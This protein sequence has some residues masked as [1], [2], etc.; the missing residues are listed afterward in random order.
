MAVTAI[1]ARKALQQAGIIEQKEGAPSESKPLYDILNIW[2][3]YMNLVDPESDAEYAAKLE[4]NLHAWAESKGLPLSLF[5]PGKSPITPPEAPGEASSIID[6]GLALITALNTIGIIAEAAS[7]GQIESVIWAMTNIINATGLPKVIQDLY[8]IPTEVGLKTALIYQM[9]RTFQPRLPDPGALTDLRAR[10][11]LSEDLYTW[12]MRQHGYAD[13]AS[14][15]MAYSKTR[16][17]DPNTI[18]ELNRRGFVP[19]ADVNGWYRAAGL[20]PNAAYAYSLLKWQLPGYADIISVY[21]KEG[22]LE[23]KWAEIPDEFI[24]YMSQ[25]GYSREWALR[26]WGKHWILPGVDLLYDMFHKEIIDYATMAKMLKYHDFEPVWRDRLILN[27]YNMIPRVDLRRAYRYNLIGPEGLT[28]RYKKLGYAEGDAV[29]LGQMA[30]RASLDRYYT[31][32]ET[33]VRAAYRKGKMTKETLTTWLQIVNTPREAIDLIIA[34]EDIAKG[35]DVLE[36]AEEPRTLS[37][38][39]ICSLYKARLL[40]HDVGL[41]KLQA[42]GYEPADAALLLSL[43][44]PRPEAP[45]QN[46]QLI[47]A[48]AAHYKE[49]LMSRDIF[50]AYLRKAGLS[51]DAIEARTDAED[52]RARYD[53]LQDLISV[54]KAGFEKD[55]YTSEEFFGMLLYYGMQYEKA[56]ALVALGELKKLPKPKRAS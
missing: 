11:F 18:L 43:S 23:E 50:Q 6:R 31:R 1:I 47:T 46:T 32:L 35:A 53:L 3:D 28:D 25:Q 9:N 7:I 16:Y 40:T 52:L 30:V 10:G 15:I 56:Q 41:T 38:A 37:A 22:Y 27:A 21:M 42:L 45:E 29:I 48:A 39:Q 55:I 12:A 5:M 33:V 36:P 34:A 20:H 4:A 44:E 49:G 26:I 24:G 13:W 14:E 54:A 17:P 19:D 51:Q 8:S 2:L